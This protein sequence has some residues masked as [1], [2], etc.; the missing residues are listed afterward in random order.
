MYDKTK[1]RKN[2]TYT[3]PWVKYIRFLVEFKYIE[4]KYS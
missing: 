1:K 4:F 2:K 3:V